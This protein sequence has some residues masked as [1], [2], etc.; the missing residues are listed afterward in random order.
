MHQVSNPRAANQS[1]ADES[2]R[3]GTCRSN[4]GWDAIDEPWTNRIVRF[5][6]RGSTALFRHRNSRT[7]PLRVQC[8]VPCA[9]AS[10]ILTSL[11]KLSRRTLSLSRWT[12]LPLIGREGKA[13]RAFSVAY[14]KPNGRYQS[15]KRKPFPSVLLPFRYGCPNLREA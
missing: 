12:S 4:V 8:S 14:N 10:L 1:I 9:V 13:C 3:P 7:S 6:L 5:L 15:R 2:G 11:T